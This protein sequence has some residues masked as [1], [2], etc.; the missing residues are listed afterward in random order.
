MFEGL[1]DWVGWS[2]S[3]QAVETERQKC[4]GVERKVSSN[5]LLR[6]G[7]ALAPLEKLPTLPA[8]GHIAHLCCRGQPAMTDDTT[9]KINTA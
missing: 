6:L 4:D 1:Q 9:T 3:R 5:E 2:G 8:W 7:P